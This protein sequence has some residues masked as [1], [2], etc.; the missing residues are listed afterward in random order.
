MADW[1]R[2]ATLNDVEPGEVIGVEVGSEPVAVC[3]VD[4][5]L[6]AVSDVCSHEFVL[7]HDGWLDGDQLE[8][9]E[10]GSRF[11]VVTGEVSGLPATQPIE[12]YEVKAE[13]E[14]VFA[15]MRGVRGE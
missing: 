3:N 12:T 6:Y 8:C 2:V 1:V 7:L 13:G 10:H 11:N 4:G 9:P 5:D 15:R 14:E